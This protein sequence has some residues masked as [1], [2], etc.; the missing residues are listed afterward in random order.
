MTDLKMTQRPGFSGALNSTIIKRVEF[1]SKEVN[2]PNLMSKFPHLSDASWR[3]PLKKVSADHFGEYIDHTVLKANATKGEVEKLCAEAKAHHFKAVCVNGYYV[4]LA[5]A[6]LKGTDI[7]VACV[8]GFPLGQMTSAVKAA[9]AQAAIQ[10][11]ATEIDMVMNVGAM[12]EKDYKAVLQDIRA[13]KAACGST[14]ALKVIFETCLLKEEDIIDACILSVAAGAEFVKT[15]TGFSTGGATPE[16]IDIML[17]VVGN[18]ASVK[19]SGGVRDVV[20]VSQYISVG[21]QRIG[22]SSGIAIVT[23]ASGS[24]GY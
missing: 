4:S 3:R 10:D 20:S 16:A 9:E 5:K 15:S 24:T 23:G 17:A 1:L 22:T 14:A 13:V 11:G 2:E 8:V 7:G 6:Q 21:V 19:A 18:A 12:V